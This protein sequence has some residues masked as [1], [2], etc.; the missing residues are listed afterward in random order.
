MLEIGT[1][2]ITAPEGT[3]PPHS[4]MPVGCRFATRCPRALPRCAGEAPPLQPAR[5]GADGPLDH[6]FA[7][8][9]PE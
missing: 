4:E 3:V 5:T 9:N 1:K 8:W 2:D 6:Q 7:C